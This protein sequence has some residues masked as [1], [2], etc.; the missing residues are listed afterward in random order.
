MRIRTITIA[1]LTILVGPPAWILPP[2]L[3]GNVVELHPET[4]WPFVGGA[5]WNA[6]PAVS[7]PL[8]MLTGVVYGLLIGRHLWIPFLATWWI[9]P[10]NIAL[11]TSMYPTSHNLLP[12][13]IV[14]FTVINLPSLF[15]AWLGKRLALRGQAEPASH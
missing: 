15:G 8:I 13:E 5:I 6:M 14:G 2:H 10:F 3:F 4:A 11:D 1:A 12:F 7:L 9:V